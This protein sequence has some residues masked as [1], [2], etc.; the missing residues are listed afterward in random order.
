MMQGDL[1]YTVSL[2]TIHFLEFGYQT[3]ETFLVCRL[4]MSGEIF[5][6]RLNEKRSFPEHAFREDR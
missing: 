2:G 3:I 5:E 4:K 1:S 6:C